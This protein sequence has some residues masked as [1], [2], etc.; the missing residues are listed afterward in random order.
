[1][2]CVE[3]GGRAA[4]IASR[5]AARIASGRR[6]H[7]QTLDLEPPVARPS[8]RTLG[9]NG[10]RAVR[11]GRVF[12]I[13]IAIDTSWVFIALLMSWSLTTGFA[14][15]HPDWGKA[16]AVATAVLATLLFFVSVVL[17]EL[18]HSL[19]AKRF[20][21]PVDRI[22]L[23]LFGGVSNIEREPPS[24]WAE[25]LTAAVGPLTSVVLGA[26]LVLLGSV[27]IRLPADV[28]H[29]PMTDLASLSPLQSLLL[30]LGP[31]NIVV[32]LFNLIPGFPLDGGRILRAAIWGVTKDLHAATRW[33]SG[34]GQ[35]IGWALVF[36][37]IAIVFG[38]HVPYFGRGVVA[39]LWLAFIG[40]FLTSAAAQT[41]RRQLVREVLEGVPVSRLLTPSQPTVPPHVDL[42]GLVNEWMVRGGDRAF[43]VVDAGGTFLGMV[44]FADIRRVPREEWRSTEVAQVMTP[45]SALIT[46]S[47][48]D[49][50]ADAAEKLAR[51]DVSQLPVVDGR[52]LVGMLLRRDVLRWIELHLQQG[53]SLLAR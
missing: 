49:D 15:W 36:T 16:T 27:A 5:R 34:V 52:S 29:E 19:V 10:G 37:G 7:R 6:A 32:G 45:R 44:T 25:F 31:I 4:R 14:S 50:L 21:V 13:E 18:A 20:G 39:G 42:D 46:A 3:N 2:I 1:M 35:A 48:R 11:L 43:P 17:H 28:V 8:P 51:A 12:G 38:A 47:P 41:W 30:W 26:L 23:F 24:A 40:W 33:A 53:R 22:T 9:M